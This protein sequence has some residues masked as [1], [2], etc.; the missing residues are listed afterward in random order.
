MTK[1]LLREG[2]R[3]GSGSRLLTSDQNCYCLLTEKENQCLLT[4]KI[5]ASPETNVLF[6]Q[7]MLFILIFK[8]K[9]YLQTHG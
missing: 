9:E 4:D 1:W 6:P 3:G 2:G 5:V 8:K 7:N